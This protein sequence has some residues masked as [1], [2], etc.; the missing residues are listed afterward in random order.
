MPSFSGK[1]K[2]TCWKLF[3][4]CPHLLNG[5]NYVNAVENVVCLMYGTV[6]DI[7]NA[8]QSFCESET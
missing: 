8:R 7:D 6:K 4:K 3:F 5:N 1:G 2:N